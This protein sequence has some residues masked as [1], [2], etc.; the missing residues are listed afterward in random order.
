MPT[1]TPSSGLPDQVT[2]S[3]ALGRGLAL[4]PPGQRRS[5]DA[6]IRFLET[7]R[8]LSARIRRAIDHP[9][10]LFEVDGLGMAFDDLRREVLPSYAELPWDEYD[11]K[12]ERVD[13]LRAGWPEHEARLL[14]FLPAYFAG[15]RDLDDVRDLVDGLTAEQALAFDAIRPYRRRALATF[16][17]SKSARD[18]S[19]W[20]IEREP[21]AAFAQT[22]DHESDYRN[23][24]RRFEPSTPAVTNGPAYRALIGRVASIADAARGGSLRTLRVA[25][26]QMHLV[27][28]PQSAV[29]NAPEGI[30]QDGS[31]YI[32]S[33]LVLERTGIEGGESVVYGPDKS[34]EYLRHTLQEGQGIFQADAGSPLWHWVTPIHPSD[35][36]S[37]QVASRSVLGFDVHLT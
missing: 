1:S 35:P 21:E 36:A 8:T 16:A 3:P 27:A 2:E 33:A 22:G 28:R 7:E 25:C 30:H 31:D 15:A 5:R 13:L 37:G 6:P 4:R 12:R 9:V 24:E 11:A 18:E 29:S 34:T 32:V 19:G 17:L 14:E 20:R 23:F 26:H 10:R